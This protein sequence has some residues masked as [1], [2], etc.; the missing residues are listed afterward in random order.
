MVFGS[1]TCQFKVLDI[2]GISERL[3]E[4]ER[5]REKLCSARDKMR[6]GLKTKRL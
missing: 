3:F 2:E 5:I 6:I 1:S 4:Q